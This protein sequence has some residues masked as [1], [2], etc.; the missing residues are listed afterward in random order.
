M[1]VR[2]QLT[3]AVAQKRP[4]VPWNGRHGEVGSNTVIRSSSKVGG[5]SAAAWGG[6][7]RQPTVHWSGEL[8]Q[9]T[10]CR[11]TA[12]VVR[13]CSGAAYHGVVQEL[14]K[15]SLGRWVE[16]SSAHALVAHFRPPEPPTSGG[17]WWWGAR[18][19][20]VRT[21]FVPGQR[22]TVG[23]RLERWWWGVTAGPTKKKN[24]MGKRHAWYR[25]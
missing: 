3:C 16:T 1:N 4:G 18:P 17:G 13:M 10:R 22:I 20:P 14:R 9:P 25:K 7:V 19:N 11:G 12:S 6:V 15:Q 24:E 5:E 21:A 2:N 23:R 8:V